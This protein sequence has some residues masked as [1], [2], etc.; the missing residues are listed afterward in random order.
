MTNDGTSNEELPGTGR[1]I[2]HCTSGR[3]GAC[4]R[5]LEV[6]RR[7]RRL[8][9]S[10]VTRHNDAVR[11][12]MLF[13]I[14]LSAL[15]WTATASLGPVSAN[16]IVTMSAVESCQVAGDSHN[17]CD[18]DPQWRAERHPVAPVTES[19]WTSAPVHAVLAATRPPCVFD[20]APL[21]SSPAPPL[22]SAPHYLR[23]TPL[24]I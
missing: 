14:G 5:L 20:T 12:L 2:R 7:R 10:P 21:T 19:V 16:D 11:R 1:C 18:A 3:Q 17:S 9:V 23:H 22:R 15:L 8:T 4:A 6:T 24:L 13:A